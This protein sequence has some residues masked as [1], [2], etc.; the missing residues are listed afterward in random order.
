MEIKNNNNKT[1]S[2]HNNN[3]NK[4]VSSQLYHFCESG[5]FHLYAYLCL[6]MAWLSV[7]ATPQQDNGNTYPLNII[8]FGLQGIALYYWQHF[9]PP[10]TLW[11]KGEKMFCLWLEERR[12]KSKKEG[13]H[14]P[15]SI[16]HKVHIKDV[17]P[18]K[19]KVVTWWTQL[20]Y[21]QRTGKVTQSQ[22]T[23]PSF[24]HQDEHRRDDIKPNKAWRIVYNYLNVWRPRCTGIG[25][26]VRHGRPR[27][28][29]LGQVSFCLQGHHHHPN[30]LNVELLNCF[31]FG[32]N[33]C[34]VTV[35]TLVVD[36]RRS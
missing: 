1:V 3:N 10:P 12:R 34:Y 20:C 30:F 5:K 17:N 9:P 18:N 22:N 19:A 2:S 35:N 16:S 13:I 31:I 29:S 8:I 4:T 26:P 14:S 7:Q 11:F 33:I 21:A 23:G 27:W 28:S 25:I 6:V 32:F 24:V 15:L 36:W